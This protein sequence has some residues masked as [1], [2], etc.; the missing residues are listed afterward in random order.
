MVGVQ[1]RL[2]GFSVFAQGTANHLPRAFYL[3]SASPKNT[4]E[5]SL[6]GGIRYNFGSSIDR[7]H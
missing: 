5:L 1:K 2:L 7:A 4:F 3:R 6:E